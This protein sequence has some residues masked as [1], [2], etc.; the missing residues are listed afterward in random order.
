MNQT[1]AEEITM[2][3]DYGNINLDTVDDGFGEQ[4][5]SPEMLREPDLGGDGM[6]ILD[7][8]SVM[9]DER[10][11]ALGYTH[12]MIG[13]RA[14]SVIGGP[15]GVS[16]VAR[17][18]SPTQSV[19]SSRMSTSHLD[20]PIH[21]DGFGGTV[22][23]TGQDILAG[24]LFEDGS[25]FDD[26]A[27]PPSLPASERVPESNYDDHDNFGG[28]PSPG[29]SSLGGSRPATPLENPMVMDQDSSPLS[30]T[31]SHAS[32]A[33]S[34]RSQASTAPSTIAAAQDAPPPAAA[35][36]AS[37][38][39]INDKDTT[40]LIQNE[41][42]TFALAPIEASTIRGLGQRAK[43]KRKL[44]VDEVKAIS[45][46][47]MKAQLSDT[48][49][50]ITTLDLAPPTKRLMHWKETGGVEKL[51]VLPGRVLSAKNISQD[52]NENLIARS[53]DEERF[54]TLI[55]DNQDQEKLP[56]ENV[57]GG[58]QENQSPN[59]SPAK[60]ETRGRKRKSEDTNKMSEYQRKQEELQKR[61]EE[62]LRKER[63]A[64][65]D[66]TAQLSTNST[67]FPPEQPPEQSP[68]YGGA[69]PGYQTPGYATPGYPDTPGYPPAGHTPT[70]ATPQF[71]DN[72]AYTSYN[73]QTGQ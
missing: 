21:D 52:Y 17:P 5:G 8:Q 71:P 23:G 39:L 3:E 13:S 54:D 60:K 46:E 67:I 50:I 18:Q 6:S 51:F 14:G 69:T 37:D 10:S 44:I 55:G 30:P 36:A 2:R 70:C 48:N 28:P 34:V 41:A 62:T 68:G 12:S 22:S 31:P 11:A 40:T 19:K 72:S 49:D 38:S 61:M 20:A 1:R 16:G 32:L 42:E 58:N 25:L 26:A 29:P 43:R 4:I 47:E 45:G 73:N 57:D 63:D 15:S 9:D 56:L 24:G 33:Q 53:H 27:P 65:L 64:S 59:I 35:A 66:N 7:N